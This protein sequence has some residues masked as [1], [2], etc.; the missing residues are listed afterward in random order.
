VAIHFFTFLANRLAIKRN[1]L[2]AAG[3]ASVSTADEPLSRH[4][5]LPLLPLIFNNSFKGT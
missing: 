5:S 2:M 1:R 3:A 4:T